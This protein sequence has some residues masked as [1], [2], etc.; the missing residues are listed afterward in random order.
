[1]A[2]AVNNDGKLF[3]TALSLPGRGGFLELYQVC[4]VFGSHGY[5]FSMLANL[6]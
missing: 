6:V 5:N 1:M 4:G 3:E 2:V